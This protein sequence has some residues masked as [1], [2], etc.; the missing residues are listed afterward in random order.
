MLVVSVRREEIR[1]CQEV[2]DERSLV[3]VGPNKGV[4]SEVGSWGRDAFAVQR[5]QGE[6][7]LQAL[8]LG[9]KAPMLVLDWGTRTL[10]R[11]VRAL[12]RLAIQSH[13]QVRRHEQATVC[14]PMGLLCT[15]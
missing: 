11:M 6:L 3:Q 15:L 5:S 12:H 1:W 10:G 8:V 13:R 14:M 2:L 4:E 9:L 7:A